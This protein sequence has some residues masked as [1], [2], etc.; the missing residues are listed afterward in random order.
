MRGVSILFCSKSRNSRPLQELSSRATDKLVHCPNT[1]WALVTPASRGIGLALAR[2]LFTDTPSLP[3]V[4][5]ARFD[6]SGTKARIL[7]G[8]N[9]SPSTPSALTSR[10]PTSSPLSPTQPRT[11]RTATITAPG[12]NLHT[13]ALAC[14]YRGCSSLSAP[15]PRSRTTPRLRP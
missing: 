8:L 9:L 11:A 13:C 1:A 7:D 14:S 12:P 10:K 2:H 4:A 5:T 15:P 3:I 6:P